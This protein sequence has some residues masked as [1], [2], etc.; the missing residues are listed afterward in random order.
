MHRLVPAALAATLAATLF[1][2]GAAPAAPP[3]GRYQVTPI[4][5]DVAG[6]AP[7]T[8]A[9]LQNTWGLARSA[10]SPWWIA[11]NGTA[12]ASVYNGAGMRVDIGGLAAQGVPG[13]PTGAVFSGIPSQFQVGTTSAPNTLAMSNFVFDSEDGTI[14]AWRPGSSAALV[15]VDMSAS[16]AVFKG[17][18]IS[19]GP[20]GPRLYATDFAHG[21]V[22]VFDGGWNEVNVPGAFV[23]PRLPKHFSPFGIQTIG[24]RVFVTYAKQQPG[25]EDEA[26]GRGLGVV[27]AYDLDGK[28][29]ARVAQRGQ[30][31]APWGLAS[32]PASFGRFGGDLLVG[33]FGDGQINA[34]QEMRN[35]H[36]EHRGTLDAAGHGKLSIDGLWALEFGNAG[37][38]GDPQTLFFTAGIDDEAHGLFGTITPQH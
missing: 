37:S 29:L 35:G 36:F 14:S 19:N 17:L 28:L 6:M 33:N 13:A 32:A 24:N 34:Y 30:L 21:R 12:S 10:T 31:N 11:N 5:S 1:A 20:S 3:G 22:D 26:H 2:A 8:D 16:D 23:D 38:N 9:N 7:T 4:A 25:S 27:D 15:T 18:A